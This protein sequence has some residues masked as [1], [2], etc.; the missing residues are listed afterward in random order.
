Y[1]K[2]QI[3]SIKKYWCDEFEALMKSRFQMKILKKFDFMSVKTASTP[4]ET[5]KPLVKDEEAADVDVHLYRSMIGSLMYL[6]ASRPDIMFTVCA[7]SRF[8]VTPKTSHLHVVKRIFRYLKGKPKLGLWYPRVSSFEL[9]VYSDSDYDGAN[10]D[11]KSTTRGCQFLGKRLISWQCKKQTIRATSTTE[12]EYVAAANCCGQGRQDD[13]LYNLYGMFYE[14]KDVDHADVFHRVIW[15]TDGNAEFHEIIDFLTRSS[16]HYALTVSPV[17]S[18]TF[19]EQFWMTAK[20]KT[21]NNVRYITATVA[22]K[23]VTILEV[24]IRSD[25][26]FDDADEIDTLNNQAIFDTIQLMGGKHFSGKVIPLFPS[27]LAQATVDEGEG[28][29][30]KETESFSSPAHTPSPST[31][32]KGT[33][34]SPGNQDQPSHHSSFSEDT[35]SARVKVSKILRLKKRIKKLEMRAEPSI[36][37]HKAWM[38]SVSLKKILAR[39]KPMKKKLM[40]KGSVSKQGRKTAKSKPTIHKDPTFDDLDD[41]LDDAMDYMETEDAYNNE[42]TSSKTRELKTMS[43]TKELSLSRDTVVLEEKDSVEKGVSTKDQVSTDQPKV[44]TDKLDEGTA[45][46]KDGNSDESATPTTIFRDDETIVEF[47]VSMSQNKA[48]QKGVEIKDTNDTDRPRTTTERLILTLKP[49][50]KIDPKD[51]GKKVLEEEDESNAESK[52]VNKDEKK[53]KMIA[54]DEEIAKKV[55]EE[56][57]AEEEKKRLAEKE[58]TKAE[59]IRDYDDIRARIDVDSI[60]AARLQEEEREKFTIE[61]RAKLLHDTIAAQRRFLAQQRSADIRILYEKV[62]RSDKNLIAIGSSEDERLI[63]DLN[64]KAAGIKKVDSIK[65]ESKEE[66]TRKRKLGIRKKMKSRKR[67]FRQDTFEGDK[68]NS[69]KENDEMG[70]CLTIAPDEDKEYDETKDLEEINLNVMIR[71]N[72]QRRYFS[73]LMRVLSIFDREDLCAVYHLVMDRYQDE[74]LKELAIPL[75]MATDMLLIKRDSWRCQRNSRSSKIRSRFDRM[76]GYILQEFKNSTL[77]KHEDVVIVVV[78]VA[79]VVV[80]LLVG[81]AKVR[82]VKET[83]NPT[84]SFM[85]EPRLGMEFDTLENAWQF[86][87][88]YGAH[89]GFDVR[90]QWINKNK[91]N[92]HISSARFVC[93]KEDV[94]AIEIDLADDSGIKAKASYELMSH[95]GGGK[96][97]VGYTLTDQKNYRRKRRQR[98]MKYGEAGTLLRRAPGFG[99]KRTPRSILIGDDLVS[100]FINKFFPTSKTTNLRNEIMRFHQRFDETFYEAWD[101]FNDLLRACPHRGFSELHQLDTFYNALN[102]NDQDSLNFAAGDMV[103]ALLL[104]KKNQNQAPVPAPAPAPAP[105]KAVEESCVTCGGAHSYQNCPATDGNIYRDNIQEFVSQAAAANFNQGNTGYR[106]PIANQIRP[107]GF[108]PVQNQGNNQ[109]RYNQN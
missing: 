65:E 77:K 99:L 82:H 35:T 64:K 84:T 39:K 22:G 108:P 68:T 1:V 80:E 51:K 38:K 8:Q 73:T 61:E 14:Q 13:L 109:N 23:P 9:E 63:R 28:D 78:I 62:K 16:I 107:P 15:K 10:L 2:L 83:S 30:P 57:E 100:K 4:I 29:Q 12:A 20:S 45:E 86:W 17:V 96:Y 91:M 95:H 18:T 44:S 67:R 21:I 31:S 48:K 6:T 102:S 59:L 58:A 92:G 76:F 49:L 37:H 60:L 93:N 88:N 25:L 89:I 106:A 54:N 66:C 87:K 52:G 24:S 98:E 103:K 79:A 33:S 53:F 50:L 47:L 34:G 56:W 74:I 19:V 71:S 3:S 97:S 7:C 32:L 27:M 101:R 41:I 5:Q 75:Q 104:D 11:R 94:Q 55:Q 69:E 85:C 42:R 40:Q 90:K 70:L 43:I 26:F 105:V 46:P 72:G 81:L 36:S